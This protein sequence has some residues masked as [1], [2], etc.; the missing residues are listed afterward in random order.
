MVA[1]LGSSLWIQS[2][3]K[4]LTDPSDLPPEMSRMLLVRTCLLPIMEYPCLNAR[5]VALMSYTAVLEM[6]PGQTKD[7]AGGILRESGL[8]SWNTVVF[9]D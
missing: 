1:L 7:L 5:N 4:M 9:I 6:M 3:G 2:S 8:W